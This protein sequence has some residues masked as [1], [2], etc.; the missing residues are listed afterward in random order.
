MSSKYSTPVESGLNNTDF[1]EYWHEKFLESPTHASVGLIDEKIKY[2][3]GLGGKGVLSTVYESHIPGQNSAISARNVYVADSNPETGEITI[4]SYY[5]S[6]KVRDIEAGKSATL[7]FT[8]EKDLDNLH[9]VQ[10]LNLSG[11]AH[12]IYSSTGDDFAKIVINPTHYE[13]SHQ[14]V[15]LA[16]NNEKVETFYVDFDHQHDHW[17]VEDITRDE[18]TLPKLKAFGTL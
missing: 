2:N 14:K 9:D 8:W 7:T 3:S 6:Q 17:K 18:T 10:I 4:S 16:N 1:I 5:G 13:V 12:V 11:P 15:D